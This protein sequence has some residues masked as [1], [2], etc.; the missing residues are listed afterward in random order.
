MIRII[1]RKRLEKLELN[2]KAFDRAADLL[3]QSDLIWLFTPILR[4]IMGCDEDRHETMK[5]IRECMDERELWRKK[6]NERLREENRRLREENEAF[7]R[8]IEVKNE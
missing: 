8:V 7:K 6:D 1:S 2:E 3:T 4:Y 5:Y